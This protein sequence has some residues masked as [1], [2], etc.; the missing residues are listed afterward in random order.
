MGR[1]CK[2]CGQPIEMGRSFPW[3]H[4]P[5]PG[6]KNRFYSR[7]CELPNNSTLSIAEPK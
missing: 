3:V 7:F 2:H 1:E 5:P 6:S 4:I